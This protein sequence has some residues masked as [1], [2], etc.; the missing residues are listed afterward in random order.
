VEW[1][2]APEVA[3]TVHVAADVVVVA[4]A[5]A[6]AAVLALPKGQTVVARPADD[7]VLRWILHARNFYP[8]QKICFDLCCHSSASSGPGAVLLQHPLD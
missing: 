4:A 3:V 2:A 6:V 7:V 1:H 5:A 8:V